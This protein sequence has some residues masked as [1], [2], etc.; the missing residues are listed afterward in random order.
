MNEITS[1]RNPLIVHMKKI[2]A[3]GN[4]R[5]RNGE[6]LCDGDKLLR[7]AFSS[8]AVVTTILFSSGK[9]EGLPADI[10]AYKI[11]RD[12]I[13]AVSPL[14]APQDVL[15]ACRIPDSTDTISAFGFHVILEGLQDPGNVGTILRTAGAFNVNSVVLTGGC[16]D[17]Y[18]PK[19]IRASMGAIFRQHIV[20]MELGGIKA[21]KE[22]G[23]KIVGAALSEKS[24]D[25]RDV[26]LR[27]AAVAIG[28][29]GRGLSPELLNLCD[30]TI[31]IPMS[32]ECE[33]LNAAVAASIVMWEARR[34][35]R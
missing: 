8:G 5:R 32:P 29:E 16:A 1:R 28:S 30:E 26:S 19:A 17:P 23:I 10:P 7:E 15:F 21:L 33:S 35:V 12:I 4:Y 14:K 3:D 9:P 20:N 6:F 13:A 31:I 27:N 34:N 11:P 25:I 24:R 2:G 18:N 22:S